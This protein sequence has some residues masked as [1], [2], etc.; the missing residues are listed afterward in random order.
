MDVV[1]LEVGL[2]GRLDATNVVRSPAVCGIASLGFDHMEVLSCIPGHD[3]VARG[4]FC[5]VGIIATN[6]ISGFDAWTR[7][8]KLTGQINMYVL[9]LSQS[10][11]MWCACADVCGEAFLLAVSM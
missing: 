7:A 8:W 2:G 6:S 4:F 1:I 9:E 11:R 10:Y 3:D 5:G